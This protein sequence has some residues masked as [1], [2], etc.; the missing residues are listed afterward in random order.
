[1]A[2]ACGCGDDVGNPDA[3]DGAVDVSDV[4]VEPPQDCVFP[5]GR[6]CK[7]WQWCLS[8]DIC[9]GCQ[10]DNGR[11][12]CTLVNCDHRDIGPCTPA[13]GGDGGDGST[14]N[15]PCGPFAQY[16]FACERDY[17]QTARA[18]DCVNPDFD[19]G[20]CPAVGC[21]QYYAAPDAI[22]CCPAQ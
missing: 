3:G 21:V 16:D 19:G 22:W 10:C 8:D 20:S 2:C 11:L 17:P 6:V 15:N 7:Q 5:S 18:F 12:W 1:M 13:D 4:T 9:N 14:P